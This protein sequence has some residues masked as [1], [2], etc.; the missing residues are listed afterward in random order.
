MGMEILL[1]GVKDSSWVIFSLG[2]EGTGKNSEYLYLGL[3][4]CMFR[5]D[6]EISTVNQSYLEKLVWGSNP[7]DWYKI[8][9]DFR[10]LLEMS[11]F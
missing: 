2:T 3:H 4:D 5:E 6:S 11:S 10:D 7:T 8:S 9:T 1:N